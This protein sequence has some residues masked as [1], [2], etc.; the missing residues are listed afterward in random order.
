M[1]HFVPE[2]IKFNKQF[3]SLLL[4]IIVIIVIIVLANVILKCVKLLPINRYQ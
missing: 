3:Q 1:L 2:K 4:D